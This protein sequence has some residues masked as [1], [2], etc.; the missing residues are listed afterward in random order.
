MRKIRAN[1]RID[2]CVHIGE[3]I[4]YYQRDGSCHEVIAVNRPKDKGCLSCALLNCVCY[5]RIADSGKSIPI[6]CIDTNKLPA[7]EEC[8]MFVRVDDLLEDL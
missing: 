7:I 2:H 6:C 1:C 8:C 5:V 3:V 4:K